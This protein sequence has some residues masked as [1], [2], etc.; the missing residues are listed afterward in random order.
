MLEEKYGKWALVTGASSG[1]GKSFAKY[2]AS[3]G[4]N[5]VMIS[6]SEPRLYEVSEE[7]IKT[8]SVLTIILP[9]D[10][11]KEESVNKIVQRLENIQVGILVNNAG[12]SLTGDFIDGSLDAQTDLMKIN[13]LIPMQLSYYFAKKMKA[14]GKGAII[15]IASVSGFMPLPGWNVYA[16]AKA[17]LI[18][19]SKSLWYELKTHNIDVLVVCPGAAK[20]EFYKVSKT[21]LR[22]IDP[23]ELVIES[24][25]NLGK[26]PIAYF[27]FSNRFIAFV[28]KFLPSKIS[29]KLGAE[30]VNNMSTNK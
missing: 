18:S 24:F 7:I 28:M 29:L 20:T 2:L 23:D 5:I 11:S 15:N 1:I 3:K 16:A 6:R 26:K 10:L 21:K 4:I 25:K 19:F 14:F 8:Y 12:Y 13:S 27:G 17:F 22:G 30:A 9:A